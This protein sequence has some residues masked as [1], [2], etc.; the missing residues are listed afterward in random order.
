MNQKIITL[1][2]VLVPDSWKGNGDI[3]G[4]ALLTND[5]KKYTISYGDREKELLPM[6][7]QEVELSGLLK[8]GVEKITLLVTGVNLVNPSDAHDSQTM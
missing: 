8:D 3:T 1:S 7:R 4:L 2:G 5:E 6:L